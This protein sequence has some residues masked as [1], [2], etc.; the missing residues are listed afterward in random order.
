MYL[1]ISKWVIAVKVSNFSGQYLRNQWTLDIGVL[2]YIGIVWP[3]EHSPE[4]WSVPPV[5]PCIKCISRGLFLTC[6]CIW[7]KGQC[8]KTHFI[9]RLQGKRV[10]RYRS[11]PDMRMLC[12][13]CFIV[14]ITSPC[15]VTPYGMVGAGIESW[16][17]PD[18]PHPSGLALGPTQPHIQWVLGL[19][20]GV[21]VAG[22]WHRPLTSIECLG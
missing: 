13:M 6:I 9:W 12:L 4:I 3:K 2:G 5:T 18:F 16:W 1:V 17:G 10:V 20:P 14:Y 22:V 21:K 7:L 15:I 19:L 8:T 11:F